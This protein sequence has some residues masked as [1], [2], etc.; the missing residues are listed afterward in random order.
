MSKKLIYFRVLL[1][2]L[3]SVLPACS[4]ST[5]PAMCAIVVGNGMEGNDADFHSVVYPGQTATIKDSETYVYVPCN[6]R[7]YYI[8]DGTK[9]DAN[10]NKIGDMHQP[11]KATT[12]SGTPVLIQVQ[13][14]WTL[15]ENP[16]AMRVFY[17]V[18]HKYTCYSKEDKG[19]G[20]NFSEPG[21]NG[22]LGENMAYAIDTAA[23]LASFTMSDDL[24]K[25]HDPN[26]TEEMAKKMAE[27]F[28]GIMQSYFGTNLDIFCG[29]GNSQWENPADPGN[30]KFNCTPVRFHVTTV[31]LDKVAASDS[32]QSG[33]SVN[34]QRLENA[35]KVYG[36]NAGYWLGLQDTIKTCQD[37]KVACVISIGGAPVS[38]PFTETPAPVAT[39]TTQS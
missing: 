39:P 32:T 26:L 31:D 5:T 37:A 6:D 10:G 3:V 16:D 33:G 22:M 17:R 25:K 12:E 24:W 19:G 11:I 29:S 30:G 27:V 13:A 35:K 14:F 18:C 7:N 2:L 21:W 9:I 36:D 34:E 4:A 1:V 8:N 23:K 38:V 20:A 15:N 28:P